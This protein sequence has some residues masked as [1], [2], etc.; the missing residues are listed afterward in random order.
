VQV[1][2]ILLAGVAAL[3]LA[4]AAQAQEQSSY[5]RD[6]GRPDDCSMGVPGP[7]KPSCRMRSKEEAAQV[8][9]AMEAKAVAELDQVLAWSLKGRSA[10][11]AA[12]RVLAKWK[13]DDAACR[14]NAPNRV[15][16]M[17]CGDLL[18]Y[19]GT[20]MAEWLASNQREGEV[21]YGMSIC[22]DGLGCQP[23]FVMPPVEGE[24]KDYCKKFAAQQAAFRREHSDKGIVGADF[25]CLARAKPGAPW[26]VVQSYRG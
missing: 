8:K 13:T 20:A 17:D 3:A 24:Y 26:T 7:G 5:T 1:K 19:G 22:L 12:Q 6:T 9:A 21:I 14:K 10:V 18:L 11:E 15:A 2:K 25:R 4:T 23:T 16:H